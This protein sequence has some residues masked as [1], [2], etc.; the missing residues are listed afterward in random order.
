MS[1]LNQNDKVALVTGASKGIGLACAQKLHADGYRIAI[2]Y[3]SRSEEAAQ[4]CEQLE[5]S[6][7]F[8]AD[9][10]DEIQ[11]EAL[12]KEVKNEFGR[13]DV[14]V[15]NA[16]QSIDQLIP[17]AK[18]SDFDY[19]LSVNL[20]SAFILSKLAAKLMIRKKEGR[21]INISSVVGF[22]GNKGQAMY[23]ATK[24][25]LVGFTK[26]IA[27]DLAPYNILCNCIAPGFIDSEMTRS[28]NEEV[29][30]EILKKIPVGR[31]GSPHDVAAAVAFLAGSGSSY[32]TGSTIH[33][34]GGMYT[35]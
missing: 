23:A 7:I 14:L 27:Q 29:R 8:Q 2:H 22:T 26:S 3:R 5:N 25:A 1:T 10:S 16:G 21:I 31:L 33:I 18:P 13:L 15:N 4:V 6:K 34:N 20:K 32:I 24:S 12:I 11:C 17:F 19:L 30:A 35:N 9:L 28:L